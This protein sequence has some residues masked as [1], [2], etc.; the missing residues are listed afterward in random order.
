MSAIMVES[1]Y[2]KKLKM[3]KA[4][5]SASFVAPNKPSKPTDAPWD[6]GCTQAR[7]HCPQ[8]FKFIFASYFT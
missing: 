8:Q 6:L 7:T 1:K 2:T 3:A 4:V 5:V